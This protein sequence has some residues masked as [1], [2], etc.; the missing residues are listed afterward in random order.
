M[1]SVSADSAPEARLERVEGKP[2]RY[3]AY[4]LEG[5]GLIGYCGRDGIITH[6]AE[7]YSRGMTVSITVIEDKRRPRQGMSRGMV[8]VVEMMTSNA[9][10]APKTDG[11][12]SQKWTPVERK[13]L[14]LYVSGHVS[15]PGWGNPGYFHIVYQVTEVS[16]AD[17]KVEYRT[18]IEN[19]DACRFRGESYEAFVRLFEVHMVHAKKHARG[20]HR[21]SHGQCFHKSEA[22]RPELPLAEEKSDRPAVPVAGKKK[23]KA[24]SH[25]KR[26]KRK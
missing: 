17:G 16:K 23:S 21:E 8:A 5:G 19:G 2:Q 18:R 4:A 13:E 20:E 10:D 25:A 24:V 3:A 26:R 9:K 15:G 7:G 14:G 6:P 11:V 12:K 1:S 22:I